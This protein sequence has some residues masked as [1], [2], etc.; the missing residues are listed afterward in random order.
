LRAKKS[1]GQHFLV[2]EAISQKIVS[3]ID[4]ETKN[5]LE[6]GPGKGA[7]SK[8][9]IKNK[10][11]DYIGVEAD[12]DMV[13]FLIEH[14]GFTETKL[15][16]EDFLKMDFEP[17]FRGESFTIIGNFPYNISS[18]I[19]FKAIENR[20]RVPELVGMFQKELAE[21]IVSGPGSKIY[22]V[23]SILTQAYY[24][25]ELLFHVPP[26]SFSPPPKVMSTI[27]RLK[28]K[29]DLHLPCNEKLFK[30]IVK[31]TFGQRRKML[32]NTLK[33]FIKDELILGEELFSKR[34]EELSLET[35]IEITNLVE[36]LIKDE[37]GK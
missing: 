15:I 19:I 28:R 33:S 17:L 20:E 10:S 7:L 31:Q 4:S 35:F 18:Q 27:I 36:K 23:A 30:S 8:Y 1:Y 6:V 3:S 29:K 21:R 26:D 2:D 32:R 14:L 34:P 24:D 22:G 5:L 16:S 9:L 37:S 11:L 12:R 13:A 25:T